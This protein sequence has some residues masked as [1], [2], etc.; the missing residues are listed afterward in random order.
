MSFGL[1]LVSESKNVARTVPDANDAPEFFTTVAD[2]LL[3]STFSFGSTN[4]PVQTNSVFAYTPAVHRLLQVAANLRDAATTN[5]YP[6]VF[7]P[8]F[9][10]DTNGNV[11]I[12]GYQ[13]VAS[14][15][16]VADPQLAQPV[17][18]IALPAG[19][20][21]NL[22]V[23]GVPWIVGAKKYLPNFNAFY[24]YNTLQVARKLQFSRTTVE[25]WNNPTTSSHFTTNQMLVISITNHLGFS[26]WNSYL[27]NYPSLTSPT[28]FVGNNVSMRLSSGSYSYSHQNYF[29]F[30]TNLTTWPGADWD[31]TVAPNV[32]EPNPDSFLPGTFENI[33]VHEA[34]LDLDQAG[35]VQGTG[36]RNQTFVGAPTS[37]PPFPNLELDTTN[38]LQAFILD[39]GHVIDYVQFTGPTSVRNLGD[40]LKDSDYTSGA[41]Y[42]FWSTNSN[43]SGLNWGILNQITACK[44]GNINP[45]LWRTVPNIPPPLSSIPNQ[46]KFFAAF[47]TAQ[48]VVAPNG[49]TYF[50]TNLVMQSPFSPIR[51]VT[52]PTVGAVNDPLVHYLASDLATPLAGLTNSVWRDDDPSHPTLP[53][54]DLNSLFSQLPIPKHYQ[55]WG[56][57]GQ[58]AGTPGVDN[59][60]YNAAYKDPLA[61][62]SDDWNFPAT[63]VLPLAALGRVHR[64]TPWQTLFLKSTNILELVDVAQ[65]NPAVGQTTWQTWTGDADAANA[66]LMSP[67]RDWRLA[68]LLAAMF[69]PN[70]ATQLT[71]VNHT[72][73][74]ALL[75]GITV[76]TNSTTTPDFSVPPQLD[77]MMMASNSPQA[78]VIAIA[79]VQAKANRSGQPFVS[80][81]DI[82]GA[83]ELSDLSPW[84][85]R[86]DANSAD[87]RVDWDISDA[88]YEMIPAQ[89]LLRL[90]PDSFG[91][92]S[93]T[94]GGWRAQFTGSD[95]FDYSLQTSTNLTG[96][97][98]I[99]TNQPV[100]GIFVSPATTD[101]ST[102]RKFFRSQ[103]QP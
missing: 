93:R 31:A 2:K 38:Y 51:T 96:W 9:F 39:N 12:T 48:G 61:W 23:Y 59:N 6:T 52:S 17:D 78:S 74:P 47:F 27:S 79:L 20:S 32:R 49:Q 55:P 28:V 70:D 58:L 45:V 34:M 18:I 71:S 102:P 95:G 72:N 83:T 80:V 54:P 53:Y 22:N 44:L 14:V 66:A 19:V 26:F 3:R 89:L 7:R 97:Q 88:A 41:G 103:L 60:A 63:N 92:M 76:L 98:T 42:K 67:V 29:T 90:R 35:T 82:L 13:Q 100:Q 84:L 24:S 91:T 25:G 50:N 87:D 37:L 21:S 40:E 43:P 16:G 57:S 62:G 73:W 65:A 69:N 30:Y 56:S 101:A 15:S 11:F 5:F 75:N 68:A 4:I 46:A 77:A 99:S 86:T 64:G 8:I 36:F 1:L 10:R 85:N 33:F 94:N 81:G